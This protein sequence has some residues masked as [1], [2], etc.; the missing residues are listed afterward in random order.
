MA[1]DDKEAIKQKTKIITDKPTTTIL[2]TKVIKK[3]TNPTIKKT[4]AKTKNVIIKN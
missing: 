4:I 2:G 3:T 1:N